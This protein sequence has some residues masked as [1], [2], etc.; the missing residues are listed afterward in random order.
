MSNS[1]QA[2][3]NLDEHLTALEVRPGQQLTIDSLLQYPERYRFAPYNRVLEEKV[4]QRTAKLQESL[5]TLRATQAQ[6]IQKEKLASLGELTAGIAH[7]IQNPLNFVNNLSEVSQELVEE[8]EEERT[9]EQRD[10]ELETELIIDL[11]DSLQKI[12]HHGRRADSIVKGMLQH[13]RASTGEK[14]PTDLNQLAD[15]YLRLAYQNL[16]AKDQTF[17][18]DLRLKLDP[19]LGQVNVA[20]QDMGR[21]LL[22]L[23]NNAFYAVQEK[24]KSL[25]DPAYQPQIE[26][27]TQAVNGKVSLRVADNG[28]GIPP[29]ILSKIYQP[30]FTTKPTGEVTG[31]GLSLSYDIITKGHGGTMEVESREGEGSEFV[32][33]LPY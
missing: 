17:T 32:I 18:A 14:Q 27:R 4:E 26:V 5:T 16:R 15:E 29:E 13:S 20:P 2:F 6:L 25:Q 19:A 1:N 10:E 21:V 12:T 7:E 28:T 11:K 31:L 23:Y 3:D 30:F 22:N 24:A 8:L 9:K 33:Q